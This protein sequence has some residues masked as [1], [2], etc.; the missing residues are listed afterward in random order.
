MLALNQFKKL[1]KVYLEITD[2]KTVDEELRL[3][4][5]RQR[6]GPWKMVNEDGDNLH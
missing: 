5:R 6:P 1:K 2:S 3:H 4:F